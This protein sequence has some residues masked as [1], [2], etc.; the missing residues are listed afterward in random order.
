RIDH[1]YH[2]LEDPKLVEKLV[3]EQIP[4]TACPLASVGVRYFES[5]D[6]FPIKKMLDLGLL[7]MLNSDDP[8]YFGGYVA[9]NYKAVADALRLTEQDILKLLKNSFKASFLDENAKQ[10]YIAQL[11][12]KF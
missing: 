12:E 5:M 7:V 8:A 10:R 11:D 2:S 9:E 4:L 6:K 1:G 3:K